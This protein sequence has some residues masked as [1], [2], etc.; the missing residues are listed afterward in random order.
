MSFVPLLSVL[1]SVYQG[2]QYLKLFL[3]NLRSQTLF[4]ELELILVLNAPN[5][6]EMEV[7]LNFRHQYERQVQILEM[8]SVESL[9]TSW[10]RAWVE[11][12]SPYLA[13]WN[14]DDRRSPDSLSQQLTAI[15]NHNDWVLCYGDYINVK[16]Y[17]EITGK[18]RYTPEYSVMHFRRSFAQ[19]GAF[20]VFRRKLSE[21]VGIFDEQFSVASDMDL[22]FR[23]AAKGLEMGRCPELLGY[24]T[25]V[26]QGL[27][28]RDL[29]RPALER[30]VIQLR[31]GVFDK[32]QPQYEIGARQYRIELIK[33]FGEWHSLKEYLPNYERFLKDRNVLKLV[34]KIRNVF[35]SIVNK[36]GLLNLM[37]RVQEKVWGKEI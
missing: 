37:Y 10:N 17:G 9:G 36:L 33:N 1:T 2:E 24:F 14:V 30:T 13:I 8:E 32:V 16:V 31:Y 35:R 27:S 22:S 28:T 12:R 23:I 15:E 18:R 5:S 19:G 11:A 34:G 20:W 6:R 4:P 7:A 26:G 29:V 25:N 21:I 3:E